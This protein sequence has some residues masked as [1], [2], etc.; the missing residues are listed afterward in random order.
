[1]LVYMFYYLLASS[2]WSKCARP[3]THDN[4]EASKM[5]LPIINQRKHPKKIALHRDRM[6]P[7]MHATLRTTANIRCTSR[8]LQLLLPLPGEPTQM[9]QLNHRCCRPSRSP[10]TGLSPGCHGTLSGG[11]PDQWSRSG[12]ELRDPPGGHA[13]RSSSVPGSAGRGFDL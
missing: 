12:M 5:D 11:V 1:M 6:N 7:A 4:I 9:Q 3:L 8:Q 10:G 13:S 2:S